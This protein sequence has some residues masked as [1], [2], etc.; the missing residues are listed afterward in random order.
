MSIDLSAII[1]VVCSAVMITIFGV[2]VN[3]ISSI[4]RRLLELSIR[5]EK[6]Q[7]IIDNHKDQF[8]DIWLKF[9]A[10]ETHLHNTDSRVDTLLERTKDI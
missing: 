8:R 10:V 6:Q 9:N 7:T 2:I 4:N 3:Y 5:T 1:T